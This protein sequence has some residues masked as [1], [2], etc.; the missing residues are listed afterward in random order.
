MDEY[1]DFYDNNFDDFDG[2]DY[3]AMSA[4]AEEMPIDEIFRGFSF[5]RVNGD[6][7]YEYGGNCCD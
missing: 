1:Q 3:A 4:G 5:H 7:P 6:D 2:A